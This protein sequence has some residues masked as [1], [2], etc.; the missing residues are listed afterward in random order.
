MN[1]TEGFV[2]QLIWREYVKHVHDITD[3][4]DNISV[5]R[6]L[7]EVRDAMWYGGGFSAPP[8]WKNRHPNHLS[9]ENNLPMAYWNA[10]SGFN[11][12]DTVVGS[13]IE[14]G[15]THHIPRLMVL[16][17]IA[18]L[19]DV[20]P[21]QLT[22]WFHAAFIDAYD[23]VVEPN[24]LGMGTFALGESMMTKPYISGAAYI[25]RMSDY[26]KECQFD[27]KKNCPITNLYWDFIFRHSESFNGNHRMSI[28]L[29]N[30]LR[31]DEEKKNI[32]KQTFEAWTQRLCK[33]T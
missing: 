24:V 15:W 9:Q 23:W 10:D 8:P 13:V 5:N 4:F 26:C 11:C 7:T 29:R 16:G 32:D 27:P 12:L 6:T 3:G 20:N 30:S 1:S 21:R 28:P 18:S 14:D 25:N 31:R 33:T 19:L 17:N 22:D 2:R